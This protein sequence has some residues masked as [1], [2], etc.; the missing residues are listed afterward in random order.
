M[1]DV[2][3]AGRTDL[4]VVV[5]KIYFVKQGVIGTEHLGVKTRAYLKWRRTRKVV[6]L[7][8]LHVKPN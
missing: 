4:E 8:R 6:V 5:L 7:G 1:V 2:A 3:D